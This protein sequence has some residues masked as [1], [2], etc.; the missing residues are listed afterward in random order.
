MACS[1]LFIC[2]CDH[3]QQGS[4]SRCRF[5]ALSWEFP[6]WAAING[7][8]FNILK[9]GVAAADRVVTVSQ[10]PPC[11]KPAC[12]ICPTYPETSTHA[13]PFTLP[14]TAAC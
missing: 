5:H 13:L 8:A 1:M 11:L 3:L 14:H 9:G 2:L 4:A 12:H 10:V 6:S 7:L